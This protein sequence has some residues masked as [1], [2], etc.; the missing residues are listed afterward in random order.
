MAEAGLDL[1]GVAVEN[2]RTYDQAE[3]R[4]VAGLTGQGE[5]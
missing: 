4:P 5:L 2:Q 3:Q 1:Q